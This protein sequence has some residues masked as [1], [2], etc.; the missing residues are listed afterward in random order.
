MRTLQHLCTISEHLLNLQNAYIFPSCV[1]VKE[2]LQDKAPV[3]VL[4]RYTD[5]CSQIQ[6]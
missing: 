4:H 2:L 6:S 3:P 5:D 1:S